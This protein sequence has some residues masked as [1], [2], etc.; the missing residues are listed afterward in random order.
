VLLVEEDEFAQEVGVAEG[1]AVVVFE[2][3]FPEAVEVA[4]LAALGAGGMDGVE[5]FAAGRAAWDAGWAG[6][7][8]CELIDPSGEFHR[9]AHNGFHDG[10]VNGLGFLCVSCRA[11]LLAEAGGE[12]PQIH[13]LDFDADRVV[14]GA[15]ACGELPANEG[16][17]VG[18]LP[19]RRT[20]Q[21]AGETGRANRSRTR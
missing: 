4:D 17:A 7:V 11:K 5:G 3:G 16:V 14:A 13:I 12:R 1:V 6:E 10:V 20:K 8:G 2:V 18:A 19:R 15:S 9:N 21:R